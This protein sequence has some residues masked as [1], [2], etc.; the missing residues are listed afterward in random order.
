M[1]DEHA[2]LEDADLSA[3]VLGADDHLAVDRLTTGEELGLGDDGTTTTG[4]TPVA[5]ALLLGLEPGR[6]LDGLR[7]G[8]VLDDALALTRFFARLLVDFDSATTTTATTSRRRLFRLALDAA[9]ETAVRTAVEA[10]LATLARRER[11][12]LGRVER[13]P[14]GH[15]RHEDLGEEPERD[16]RERYRLGGSFLGGSILSRSFLSRSFLSR[17]ILSRSVLRRS[18]L[19]RSVLRRSVLRGSILSRSILSRGRFLE[20]LGATLRRLCPLDG[21][22]CGGLLGRSRRLRQ[23]LRGVSREVEGRY[24]VVIVVIGHLWLLPARGTACSAKSRATPA[25][26]ANSL[27]VRPAHG[28]GH[29]GHR[30]P[31][32]ASMRAT[33]APRDAS[34]IIIAPSA[35][36]RGIPARARRTLHIRRASR[37]AHSRR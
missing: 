8:D 20:G 26:A 22:L 3:A 5:A 27:G 18:V 15:L 31:K 33:A 12:D 10:A 36:V 4:V 19:R 32:S 21:R 28:S 25:G 34:Q 37:P 1:L 30:T 9:V 2:V 35:P 24:V 17:S 16:S 7:L 11:H 29:V 6:P 23:R 13:E 14:G